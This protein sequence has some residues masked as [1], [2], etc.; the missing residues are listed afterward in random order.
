M[1]PALLLVVLLGSDPA[2]PPFAWLPGLLPPL[3]S[4][5]GLPGFEDYAARTGWPGTDSVSAFGAVP[6]SRGSVALH[7]DVPRSPRGTVLLVH[8]YMDHSGLQSATAKHLVDHGWA[9]AAPDLPG[10]GLSSGPR[11]ETSSFSSYGEALRVVLDTLVGRGA[12]RPWMA[13]GH[14]TGGSALLALVS[15]GDRRIERAV[16]V[17]PLVRMNS[18]RWI[19]AAYPVANAAMEGIDRHGKRR[20]THDSAW[21]DRMLADPLELRRIPLGW[22]RAAL[23]W[24]RQADSIA[25]GTTRWM[26]V[27]GDADGVVDAK[28]GLEVLRRRIPNL[29][30]I[31]IPGGMHHLLNETPP[32]R[33]RVWMEIDE[34]LQNDQGPFP[35][36]SM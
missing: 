21:H 23:D 6:W 8:G 25:P 30:S 3:R 15:S 20:S 34:F 7:Y 28:A 29:R 24:E 13:V 16:L 36:D 10:H 22:V 19:R 33:L 9:V 17:A 26:L 32:W 5:A 2:G 12:P 27:Q 1:T 18:A 11:G 14:S 31:W 4:T 35:S